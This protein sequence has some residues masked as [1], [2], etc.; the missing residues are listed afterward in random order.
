MTIESPWRKMP[1]EGEQL[2]DRSVDAKMQQIARYISQHADETLTLQSLAARA[3]MSSGHFQ[4]RF[5]AALGITPRAFQESCRIQLFK[6][7]LAQGSAVADA[8][9]AAGYGSSS[10]V[11]EKLDR[12]LGMTPK[13]YRKGGAGEV[14]S[15]EIA[16]TNLGLMM[17]AAT[18]RGICFLQ[19]ADARTQLLGQLEAE[20]PKA[21]LRPMR[22]VQRPLFD[23]WIALLNEYLSGK[24]I[25]LD[26]PLDIRGTAFQK[27]VWDYLLRIP[28]G[29][30]QSYKE[31]AAAVGKPKAVRAVASAC[32]KNRL[33]VCIPCHR[34]IRGDGSLAGYRWGLERKQ[35]LLDLER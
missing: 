30:V 33:A 35:A 18:E 14:I 12:N 7:Q 28:R 29:S 2:V 17:V 27:L 6:E 20:Y 21:E 34:V 13:A 11:Y 15:Y 19:F 5:K 22:A 25:Q 26:L 8:V 16:Q 10:R 1:N 24:D 3:R 4:K 31:V 32:A 9:Y 23:S